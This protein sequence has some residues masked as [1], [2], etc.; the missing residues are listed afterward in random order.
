M[1]QAGKD[2]QFADS[3]L[4][5]RRAM[6][7]QFRYE[8]EYGIFTLSY[9]SLLTDGGAV[10]PGLLR[11]LDLP[12]DPPIVEAMRAQSSFKFITR[13][14]SGVEDRTS[15]FRK[16][17]AGDWR[18]HFTEEDKATFKQLAGDVLTRLT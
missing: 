6:E 11:F 15:F 10:D 7:E 3:I 12:D 17:T 18:N 2:R 1:N 13:R 8:D 16:G 14:D 9:E 4:G 5:W